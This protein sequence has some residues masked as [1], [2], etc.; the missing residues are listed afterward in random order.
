MLVV[1]D[2]VPVNWLV[3]VPRR[4]V[5]PQPD[6]LRARGCGELGDD[7]PSPAPPRRGGHRVAGQCRRPE[8]ETVVVLG[9]E[10]D[11]AEPALR[12][13]ARPLAR[14]EGRGSEHGG[15][16]AAGAP[17]G[18]REGIG[19]EVE[20]E[21]HLGELPPEL[22]VGRDGQDRERRRR[23]GRGGGGAMGAEEE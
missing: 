13:D 14:V 3:A 2:G 20:E 8:A 7:V 18:V 23:R 16:G 21:R 5:Q 10:H 15:V 19:P 6:P 11:A 1:R 9:R 12:R 4:Q 17:L 22:R